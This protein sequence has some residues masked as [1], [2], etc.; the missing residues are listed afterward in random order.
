[1]FFSFHLTPIC[2]VKLKTRRA[3]PTFLWSIWRFEFYCRL[4]FGICHLM[5]ILNEHSWPDTVSNVVFRCLQ[6][7]KLE[8][9]HIVYILQ[10]L[11]NLHSIDK[12]QNTLVTTSIEPVLT[13]LTFIYMTCTAYRMG[14]YESLPPPVKVLHLLP[15]SGHR[16]DGLG[17]GSG[18][19]SCRRKWRITSERWSIRSVSYFSQWSVKQEI[20]FN[21]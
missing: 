3:L 17:L 7:H 8:P 19:R 20:L 21:I 13:Q 1:M 16:W 2:Q 12:L 4:I 15:I 10:Q 14:W 6:I 11:Q 18:S 5:K 9:K